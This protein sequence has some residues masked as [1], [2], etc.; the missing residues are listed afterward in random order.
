MPAKGAK[1]T[2]KPLIKPFITC[3]LCYENLEPKHEWLGQCARVHG[4]GCT[5]HRLVAVL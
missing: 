4:C 5:I 3:D 2:A 1:K